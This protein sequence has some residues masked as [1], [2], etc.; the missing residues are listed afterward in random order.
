MTDT[1]LFR[2]EVARRTILRSQW[3]P[4]KGAFIDCKHP[5]SQLKDNYSFIGIGVSQNPDQVVNLSEP[6]G[7]SFGAA[8]MPKGV[9]NNLHLHFTSET[10]INF[11]GTYRIRWGVGGQDGEYV[12]ND[13]DVICVPQWIFRGF[14]NEGPDDG[15][16]LT[17][18][19]RDETGGIIWDPSVLEAAA[20]WGLF[21]TPDNRLVDTE[22]GAQRPDLVIE[23]M[24]AEQIALL[25]RIPL[26]GMRERVSTIAD[27]RFEPSALL[28]AAVPGGAVELDLVIGYGI[29]ENRRQAPRISEPQ[30]FSLAW[31]RASQD[32]AM[33]RHRHRQTQVVTG[34]TGRWAVTLGAPG[35]SEV[36]QLGRLDSLSIPPDTWREFRCIEA[37]PDGTA[38]LLVVT[39]G[40]DRVTLDWADD[41]AAAARAAGWVRDPNGYLAPA[42]VM[43]H[44]R[45]GGVEY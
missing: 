2:D 13:G 41:V 28:C 5:G 35:H 39:G 32:Q 7:F 38:E 44:V 25:D 17:V 36:V 10:F 37:G 40:D 20:G 45:Y 6:H 4:C 31:L 19:G 15:I 14:T 34:R 3:V 24:S 23:P 43:R 29:T 30:S 33:L 26:E 12:S 8:G 27:R 22:T 11:G 18:L 42:E 9:T 21:L 1:A 16:L